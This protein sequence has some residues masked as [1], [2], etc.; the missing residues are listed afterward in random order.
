MT[1]LEGSGLAVDLP[2]GWEG[3]IGRSTGVRPLVAAPGDDQGPTVVHLA[4]FPLPAER[5]DFGAEAVTQ[6]RSGDV[7]VALFEYGP[8][9]AD[10]DLFAAQGLP[11]I[12]AADFDRNALQHGHPGQSGLQRF[13]R[14]GSR[15]FCLYVVA[16]SHIDRADIVPSVNAVLDSLQIA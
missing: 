14:V 10:R 15:A 1:R 6:M 4:N 8:G 11:R 12:R 9:A 3:Q 13:F 16:G 7:F 5:A 2:T